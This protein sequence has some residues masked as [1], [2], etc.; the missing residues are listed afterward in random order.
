[1]TTSQRASLPEKEALGKKGVGVVDSVDLGLVDA[2]AADAADADA[3]VA[4]AAAAA[5]AADAVDVAD[6]L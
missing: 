4:A 6:S 2:D 3:V 1:M 5:D